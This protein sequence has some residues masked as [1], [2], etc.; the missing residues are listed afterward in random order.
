MAVLRHSPRLSG[1]RL[2]PLG[3]GSPVVFRNA[4]HQ[5]LQAVSA[6]HAPCRSNDD[7]TVSGGHL[8]F[9]ADRDLRV[10]EHPFAEAKPLAVA[11]FLDLRNRSD[12]SFGYTKYGLGVP[13]CQVLLAGQC[14]HPVVGGLVGRETVQDWQ[15][16]SRNPHDGWETV[17]VVRGFQVLRMPLVFLCL[18]ASVLPARSSGLLR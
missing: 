14:T 16:T 11:P 1:H 13:A 6:A 5:L 15:E 9:I 17:K 12:T 7:D 3:F 2:S 18:R 8:Y 10:F 4:R